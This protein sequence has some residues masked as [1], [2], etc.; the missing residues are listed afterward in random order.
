M[1]QAIFLRDY[2]ATDV[3]AMFR[4]DEACFAVEFRFD[5]DSMRE[6]AE[7]RGAT[8]L[9]AEDAA[10]EL[11][12][13][14]IAHIEPM[15]AGKR[16]YVVTLDVAL[17]SRRIGVAGRLMREAERRAALAGAVRMELHVFVENDAAIRFYEGRGYRRMGIRQNFYGQGR[18]GWAYRKDLKQAEFGETALIGR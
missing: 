5:R 14:V 12:G 6:F 8:T 16:G 11:A 4:L 13:F 1:S 7:E 3:G 17:R 15:A 2:R 9:I 18:D 10:G